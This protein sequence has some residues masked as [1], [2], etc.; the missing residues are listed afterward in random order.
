M[1]TTSFPPKSTT[2][3]CAN[4]IYVNGYVYTDGPFAVGSRCFSPILE[5]YNSCNDVIRVKYASQDNASAKIDDFENCLVIPSKRYAL[6]TGLMPSSVDVV[7]KI[8]VEDTCG[9]VECYTLEHDPVGGY[10]LCCV[11]D[12]AES[13]LKL[14]IARTPYAPQFCGCNVPMWKDTVIVPIKVSRCA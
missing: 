9:N 7:S 13:N 6:L 14:R 2:V 3:G 4:N 12:S 1:T 10:Y 5:I 11:D 8:S